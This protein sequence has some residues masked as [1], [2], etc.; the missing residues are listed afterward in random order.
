MPKVVPEY[1]TQ[2]R[3]RIL[4]AARAVFRRKGFRTATMDD[5]AAEVG[6]SKGALYLYFRTKAELLVQIQTRSREELLRNWESLLEEGDIAEAMARTLDDVFTGQVDPAVFHELIAE[7]T[8]D[9]EVRRAL[10]SDRRGDHRQLLRF[11]KQLEGRGRIPK[12][13]EPAVTTEIVLKLFQ[14]TMLEMM[15]LGQGRESREAL[16]RELRLVLGL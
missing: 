6:V 7:S 11:L 13:S 5:I 3:A 8:V 15:L 2:A 10:L 9:P 4:D 1:K 12:L 14:G 16:T